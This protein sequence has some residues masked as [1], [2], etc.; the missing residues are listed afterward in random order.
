[1]NV[2]FGDKQDIGK[3]SG[4]TMHTNQVGNEYKTNRLRN[5]INKIYK[6]NP[7]A[8]DLLLKT[9]AENADIEKTSETKELSE[10]EIMDAFKKEIYEEMDE[11][12]S[13]Y[14]PKSLSETVHITDTAFER[15]KND[16]KFRREFMEYLRQG[17]Y[18]SYN[19][20]PVRTIGFIFVTERGWTRNAVNVN[21]YD[22]SS[23]KDEK[24]CID[25][26][27]ERDAFYKFVNQKAYE[28]KKFNEYL[29][30]KSIAR[31]QFQEMLVEIS[32]ERK[33][34]GKG[35]IKKPINEPVEFGTYFGSALPAASLSGS[36]N[37]MG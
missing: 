12:F 1:M 13:H 18:F 23:N 11:I 5:M 2:F 37:G 4:D 24:K 15:L 17:I 9:K 10:S 28:R 26:K 7:S 19:R 29:L 31:K 34:P 21:D 30:N 22:C 25:K 14:G 6:E 8:F 27:K 36:F 35:M 32:I 20:L 33:S 3:F 16:P